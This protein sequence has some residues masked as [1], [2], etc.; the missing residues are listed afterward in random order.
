MS[1]IHQDIYLDEEI[2]TIDLK[3]Y[4]ENLVRSLTNSFK[5]KANEFDIELSLEQLFIEIDDA[6]PVGLILNEMVSYYLQ[7]DK[8][9]GLTRI[10]VELTNL[11]DFIRLTVQSRSANNNSEFLNSENLG[12]KIVRSFTVKWKAE[13]TSLNNEAFA[14]VTIDIPKSKLLGQVS[15]KR[16]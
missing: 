4:I 11:S 8:N 16:A 7:Q 13:V 6:I 3:L 2:K 1:M 10:S 14:G 5:I 12:Y 15:T 9:N